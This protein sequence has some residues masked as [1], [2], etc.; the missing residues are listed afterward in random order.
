MAGCTESFGA[1]ERDF[2]LVKT[3]SQGDTLWTRTYGGSNEDYA[4]SVQQ[5]DDGGYILAGY[6]ESFGAGGAD[7]YLVKTGPDISEAEP[8]R[9]SMPRQYALYPN[10]P[11]PFNPSTQIAFALPKNDRVSLKVFNL[12]GQDVATL[13]DEMQSAGTHAA[14][15]D[16]SGLPSGIYLC[17]LRAGSFVETK[18]MVLLK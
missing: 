16:G 12:L 2:Y 17:R 1:G 5:T 14:F 6:T 10:F 8:V 7:F 3:N 9:I 18:K 11:N 15:F 13:V 4:Y